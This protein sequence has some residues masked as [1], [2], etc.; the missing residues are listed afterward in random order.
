MP[1][2]LAYQSP[3]PCDLGFPFLTPYPKKPDSDQSLNIIYTA[4]PY[5]AS[6]QAILVLSKHK[7][8]S[9]PSSF[10]TSATMFPQLFR[11]EWIT[12]F[13]KL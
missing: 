5:L 9:I 12:D 7:S 11:H 1:H 2:L 10:Q 8:T 3:N 13:T 6:T 4:H